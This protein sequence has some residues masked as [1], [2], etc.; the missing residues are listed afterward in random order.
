M[1]MFYLLLHYGPNLGMKDDIDLTEI[2]RQE[3]W[4]GLCLRSSAAELCLHSW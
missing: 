2:F 4:G 3:L 1:F